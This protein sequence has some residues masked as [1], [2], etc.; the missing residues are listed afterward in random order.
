MTEARGESKALSPSAQ[1]V[2]DTLRALGFAHQ[3]IELEQP[4]RT[5]AAAA[6]AVGCDVGQIA[7]SLIFR[8]ERTVRP[9]LVVARG[10][11]RVDE[12]KIASLVGE[13]IGRAD[14]AFVRERTGFAIGGVPPL[15]HAETIETLIDAE[16]MGLDILW[17]AAGHPNSLFKVTPQELVAMSRGRV[18][19]VR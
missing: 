12:A 1:K 17:A 13:P 5:A 14:P 2:Q 3:V 6:A 4:V 15:G 19:E 9:I 8:A 10:G 16:L 11:R 7:N 18:A